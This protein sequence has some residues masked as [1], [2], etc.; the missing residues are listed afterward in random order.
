M[1]VPSAITGAAALMLRLPAKP[2]MNNMLGLIGSLIGAAVAVIAGLVVLAR[3]FETTDE[4]HRR[5]IRNLLLALQESGNKLKKPEAAVNPTQFITHTQMLFRAA[6]TVSGELRATGAGIAVI[7]TMFEH[8]DLEQ[9]LAHLSRPGLGVNVAGLSN[10]GD[11]VLDLA[12]SSLEFL[13]EKK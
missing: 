8:G 9:R 13:G 6:K 2:D 12:N 3:Q 11:E 5:T 7:A 4:R 1:V 10:C